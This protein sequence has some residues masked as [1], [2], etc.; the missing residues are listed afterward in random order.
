MCDLRCRA[1]T[2]FVPFQT[3]VSADFY[4]NSYKNGRRPFPLFFL[5]FLRVDFNGEKKR[6]NVSINNY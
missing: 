2:F 1:V 3:N 6:K 4:G 5:F